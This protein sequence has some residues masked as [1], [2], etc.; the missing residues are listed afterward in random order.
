MNAY[1]SVI[2]VGS[3]VATTRQRREV[4]GAR[5][6][7]NDVEP[8]FGVVTDGLR[9]RRLSG[10]DAAEVAPRRDAKLNVDIGEAEIAV[11]QQGPVTGLGQGMRQGDREPGLADAAFA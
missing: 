8:A 11:E 1:A 10:D 2:E 4:A 9:H 5:A 7:G 3:S 6:A